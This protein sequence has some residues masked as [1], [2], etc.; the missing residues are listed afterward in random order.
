MEKKLDEII[1]R[2]GGI[3]QAINLLFSI[4]TAKEQL[5]N[6]EYAPS[7][8][9]QNTEEQCACG[10]SARCY[11]C[12]PFG[13]RPEDISTASDYGTLMIDKTKEF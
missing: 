12:F 4:E 9:D 1:K 5:K 6:G 8:F 2:L 3:E 10:T 11:K 13:A 7:P